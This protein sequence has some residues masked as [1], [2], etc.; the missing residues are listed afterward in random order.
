MAHEATG[1]SARSLEL[2]EGTAEAIP[3]ATDSIDTVVTTWTLCSIPDIAR[4]PKSVASCD[5]QAVCCSSSTVARPTASS[6]GGK[7]GSHRAGS[8]SAAAA[9][10]IAQSIN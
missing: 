10:S 6:G 4:S 8:T 2:L 7:I 5:R 3:L 1:A 9:I